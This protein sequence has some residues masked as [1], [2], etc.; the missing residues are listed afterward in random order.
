MIE[1]IETNKPMTLNRELLKAA[2]RG[3]EA[4][5]A[6]IE[7]HIAEIREQLESPVEV[8]AKQRKQ[9]HAV[10][11]KGKRKK[12]GMS[13]EGRAKIAAASRKRWAAFRKAKKAEAAEVA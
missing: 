5:R 2:L 12:G 1:M 10:A 9:L 4:Q 7:A 3:Y 11:E 6:D 8:I 13:A